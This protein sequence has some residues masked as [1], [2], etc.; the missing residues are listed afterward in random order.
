MVHLLHRLYGVDAPGNWGCM[1]DV[2][3]FNYFLDKYFCVFLFYFSCSLR[4]CFLSTYKRWIKMNIKWLLFNGTH[5]PSHG[6]TTTTPSEVSKGSTDAHQKSVIVARWWGGRAGEDGTK[7]D[8][9]RRWRD[10]LSQQS[11]N[12]SPP[13]ICPHISCVNTNSAAEFGKKVQSC[14]TEDDTAIGS[15]LYAGVKR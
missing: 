10:V 9:A 13:D 11:T 7:D 3:L 6:V 2:W 15:H 4:A 8:D 14:K 12:I 1:S 5:I